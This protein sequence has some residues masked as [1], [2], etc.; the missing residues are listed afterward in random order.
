M[1]IHDFKFKESIRRMVIIRRIFNL[2]NELN[3]KL[4]DFISVDR[5]N[6]LDDAEYNRLLNKFN[7]EKKYLQNDLEELF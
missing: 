6:S 2:P 3:I 7:R 4:E 1:K 5:L